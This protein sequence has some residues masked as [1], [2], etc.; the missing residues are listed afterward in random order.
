M[1][2]RGTLRPGGSNPTKT[3]RRDKTLVGPGTQQG[4][5]D[6]QVHWTDL[7]RRTV[8]MHAAA[9]GKPFGHEPIYQALRALGIRED[10]IDLIGVMEG[11]KK[12]QI[13]FSSS[14]IADQFLREEG[15]LRVQTSKVGQNG[16]F[17][18]PV[19]QFYEEVHTLRVHWMP[20]FIPQVVLEEVLMKHVSSIKCVVWETGGPKKSPIYIGTQVVVFTADSDR[21]ENI[22]DTVDLNFDGKT[23]TV[24]LTV[25]GLAPRCH[26]CGVRGHIRSKC[27]TAC[28]ICGEAHPTDKHVNRGHTGERAAAPQLDTAGPTPAESVA[29]DKK[30]AL[31]RAQQKREA[32]EELERKKKEELDA[33]AQKAAANFVAMKAAEEA[34]EKEKLRELA[35]RESARMHAIVNAQKAGVQQALGDTMLDQYLQGRPPAASTNTQ[36]REPVAPSGASASGGSPPQDPTEGRAESGGQGS[37]AA[38]KSL[39]ESSGKT[40]GDSRAKPVNGGGLGPSELSGVMPPKVVSNKA[41]QVAPKPQRTTRRAK[42][43]RNNDHGTME[44]V[45]FSSQPARFGGPKAY[46]SELYGGF[47]FA[48][49]AYMQLAEK[50]RK[51]GGEGAQEQAAPEKAAPGPG[52][53]E[54]SAMEQTPASSLLSTASVPSQPAEVP[55]QLASH[56]LETDSIL[57]QDTPSQN[58]VTSTAQ[59]LIES[60]TVPLKVALDIVG[61]RGAKSSR[62]VE[63]PE[64]RRSQPSEETSSTKSSREVEVPGANSSWTPEEVSQ[65]FRLALDTQGS[66]SDADITPGQRNPSQLSMYEDGEEPDLSTLYSEDGPNSPYFDVQTP[67]QVDGASDPPP[68]HSP[69]LEGR[70]E[71]APVKQDGS[72]SAGEPESDSSFRTL[73]ADSRSGDEKDLDDSGDSSQFY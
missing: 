59:E 21:M 27:K 20:G 68:E 41:E 46:G 37:V 35:R 29:A 47:D 54:E 73:P 71:N 65:G 19:T 15:T 25:N 11:G 43:N 33:R 50:R 67:P 4:Q 1:A 72:E 26:K 69:D 58:E 16:Y 55:S 45:G 44:V 31:E 40:P 66:W 62:K 56:D 51:L 34:A 36:E 64:A 32:A 2:E 23:H 6:S 17:E 14:N 70:A 61:M 13:R 38:S 7:F 60:A 9:E 3:H 57:I 52:T 42:R 48:A 53:G 22:P 24:L 12:W 18:C 28:E 39:P 10:Q 5:D 49:R 63:V 8:M 30:A